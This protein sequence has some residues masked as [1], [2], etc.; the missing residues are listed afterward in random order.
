MATYT[1]NQIPTSRAALVDDEVEVQAVGGGQSA[2]VTAESIAALGGPTGATGATGDPG[3]TGPTGDPGPGP[4]GNDGDVQTKDG[5]TF[6]GLPVIGFPQWADGGSG[7]VPIA[8]GAGSGTWGPQSGSVMQ[9]QTVTLNA[10]DLAALDTTAF[11]LIDAQGSGKIQWPVWTIVAMLTNGVA[12]Y[13]IPLND[14]TTGCWWNDVTDFSHQ[15]LMQQLFDA[16]MEGGI[17]GNSIIAGPGLT[18]NPDPNNGAVF[19]IGANWMPITTDIADKPFVLKVS[20]PITMPDIGGAI[21]TSEITSV[22]N[23]AG[24]SGY[25]V[26]DTFT[27]DLAITDTAVTPAAGVVDSVVAGTAGDIVTVSVAPEGGGSGYLAGDTGTVDTI[28]GCAYMIDTVDSGAVTA[29]HLTV[30]GN[31]S[32]SNAYSTTNAG[33]QPGIGTGFTVSVDQ[34]GGQVLTYHLTSIPDFGYVVD[35]P[36]ATSTTG[37]GSGLQ[38]NVT[39]ITPGVNPVTMV[40]KSVFTV[41]DL[42]A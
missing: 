14:N 10:D 27:V 25:A 32:P 7:E 3:P 39:A 33:S 37:S 28:A 2:R 20:D 15:H 12:G 4:A 40:V 19:A 1:I 17:P 34:V 22:A 29:F 8:N 6:A 24:G 26:N 21:L 16:A 38:L 41:F 42:P 35:D 9:A 36:V 13:F 11:T 30:G 23:G 5:A 18:L 31:A